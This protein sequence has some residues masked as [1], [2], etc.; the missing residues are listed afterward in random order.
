MLWWPS[1]PPLCVHVTDMSEINFNMVNRS[2]NLKNLCVAAK[3]MCLAHI[4]KN[5]CFGDHLVG[6][7]VHM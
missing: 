6:H 1:C 4:F 5:L 3:I 7:F 2:L